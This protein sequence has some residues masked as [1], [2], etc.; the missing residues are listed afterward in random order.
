MELLKF[1]IEFEPFEYSEA[2]STTHEYGV[3]AKDAR[4]QFEKRNP[5]MRV[6]SITTA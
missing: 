6:K 3:D 4:D 1:I 2:T 5:G